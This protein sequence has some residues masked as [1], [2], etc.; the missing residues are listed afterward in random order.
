MSLTPSDV[1]QLIGILASL[2]TSIIAII[3][4]VLTLKQNSKMIDETSR[5]YVAIYAKTTNFQSTQYYL[6]IKNFGQTGATISSIKCSP[7]ITPFSIRSDRIPFSNGSIL[8]N[9][10]FFSLSTV[11]ADAVYASSASRNGTF[12][13]CSISF[14]SNFC[15]CS[16]VRSSKRYI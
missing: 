8:F 4:S 7:D 16:C 12:S 13:T 3:I 10:S 5:P 11:T 2:I 6:V 9:L 1:I 15:F 14:C